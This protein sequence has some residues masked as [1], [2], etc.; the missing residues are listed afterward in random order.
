MADGEPLIFTGHVFP[1][2]ALTSEGPRKAWRGGWAAVSA[3]RWGNPIAAV[4]GTCFELY[5]TSFRAALRAVAHILTLA[6][7]PHPL[8]IWS[9]N[10]EV[11]TGF[12]RGKAWTVAAGREGADLWRECW[13]RLED[14]GPGVMVRKVE[15]HAS[16]ADVLAGRSTPQLKRGNGAADKYAVRAKRIAMELFDSKRNQGTVPRANAYCGWVAMVVEHWEAVRSAQPEREH[17]EAA[18]AARTSATARCSS[19]RP[20][21]ASA[22]PVSLHGA[23]P[24]KLCALGEKW[25]C[26]ACS[27]SAAT[28]FAKRTM[29]RTPMHGHCG[30]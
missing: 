28:A 19:V 21:P 17:A 27:R 10:A 25:R 6:L 1:D 22:R 2:G 9:D 12:Q 24:H 8:I 5:A 3:D 29:A 13:R 18:Q 20:G 26:S 30:V 11:V 15:G 14:I 16:L 23:L 7:P 4:Y